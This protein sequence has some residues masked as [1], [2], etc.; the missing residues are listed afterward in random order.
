[1]KRILQPEGWKRPKGYANGIAA[2]GRMVFTAGLIGWNAQEEF[3]SDDLVDQTRQTLI[4]T[5]A[6]LA[7]AGAGPEHIV[8]MTWYITDRDDY[9]ARLKDI[10]MVWKEI[11]GTQ[12]PCMACVQV[13][14][15]MEHRAKI[16]IE[17]TAVVPA[18]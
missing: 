1:M 17:T 9:L 2:E 3:E 12:F 6:I 15:L 18:S 5:I 11:I 14:A 13:A 7:E 8:R 16:E 4:N 10:G